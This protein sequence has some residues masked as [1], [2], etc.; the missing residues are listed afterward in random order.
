MSAH[1]RYL[2]YVLLH[3]WYV[4]RAGVVINGWKPSWLW[5]LLVHD[6]SKFRPSEWNPDVQKFY[7]KHPLGTIKADGKRHARDIARDRDAAFQRAWLRHIQRNDHHWQHWLLHEDSG[8]TIVLLPP[9]VC[10]DEMV[11]DWLAA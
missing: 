1:W 8:K 7:G 4:L 11:A 3:K 6:L 5:R 10:V 2:R 9:A